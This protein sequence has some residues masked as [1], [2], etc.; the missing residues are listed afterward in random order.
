MKTWK[1]GIFGFLGIIAITFAFIACDK[2]DEETEQPEYRETTITLNF[3]SNAY[4]I[5]VS[6]TLLA[7]EWNGV[8][9]KVETLLETAYPANPQTMDDFDEQDNFQLLFEKTG[10]NVIV[11]KTT[12]YTNYKTIGDRITLCL[13]FSALNSISSEFVTSEHLNHSTYGKNI[14]IIYDAILRI[15]NGETYSN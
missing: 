13:C 1:Q 6:G 2:G 3:G 12:A 10:A 9:S 4:T 5:K 11:E 15:L 8:P 14:S 7:S